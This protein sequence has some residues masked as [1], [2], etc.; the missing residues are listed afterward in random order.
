MEIIQGL[1]LSGFFV[2]CL[3]I[4]VK[5]K[6]LKRNGIQV[7]ANKPGIKTYT[8]SLFILVFFIVFLTELVSHTF[9]SSFSLL[10]DFLHK[11]LFFSPPLK[12]IGLLVI[13]LSVIS[14]HFTLAE[15]KN[16]LRFGLNAN[17]LGKLV[18][19][20]IFSR[21][22]NPFFVSILLQFSG[23]TLVFSTSFFSIITVLSAISIHL[24]ILKEEKFMYKN[25]GDEYKK[26]AKKVRRYF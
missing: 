20:G 7:S 6:Q 15:F 3:Q 13:I 18:T 16:S 4:L 12:G 5:Q 21:S 24:F 22:R 8:I 11:S 23:I 2:F 14:M 25:Y 9:Q 1:A 10:P 26:Y 17:N 19:S